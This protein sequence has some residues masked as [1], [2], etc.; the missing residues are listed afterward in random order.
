MAS[1]QSYKHIAVS[2]HT[3][4][5]II[6]ECREVFISSGFK[7]KFTQETILEDMIDTYL[8]NKRRQCN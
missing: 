3:F 4:N 7:G 6:N 2:E 5:R 1:K 8:K